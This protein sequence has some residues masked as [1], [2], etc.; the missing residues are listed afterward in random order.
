MTT[1]SA[2]EH[3]YV[4]TRGIRLHVVVQGPVDAPLVLL[5]HGF[6]GG[7]FDWRELMPELLG[8]A[9]QDAAASAPVPP[10]RVAAVDLR[11]YGSSDKTPRGYD[12]TTAAS[13]MCGTIRALGHTDALV[14]GH[15]EGGLIAWTMAAHEPRRV[16]GIV[17]LAS[18]HP[19]VLART[20]LVHPVSQ[21]PRIR[22]SLF[23]QLPRL[24][25]RRLL[26]DGAAEVAQS[27]RRQVSP[28]FR[29]TPTCEAHEQLRREGMQI[30]KV[31]HLSC[32]YRR[33]T[34]RSRLRPEG[35]DFDRS[36]PK[37]TEAPATCIDG[38]MD[39]AYS[40]KIARRSAAR[41]AP[42][43]SDEVLYGV[44]H[45]PHIEDPPAVAALIR[46]ADAG[47]QL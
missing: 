30:D 8:G 40:P 29:G 36:I 2:P 10:V 16:R 22:N 43:S 31:A 19:L 25:E 24:P 46:A 3:R 41:G 5:I 12:L 38:S 14:V 28:G 4:H 18:S 9:G 33:W 32:E 47:H 42:G 15:G 1:P 13:D 37:R 39:R 6:A 7:H 21:W 23:S 45:F 44:G 17:T 35:G 20:V 11:G 27:F 34:L 26:R